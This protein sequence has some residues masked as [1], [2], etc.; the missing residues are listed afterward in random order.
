MTMGGRSAA[1]DLAKSA[2]PRAAVASEANE[3]LMM[4]C[5]YYLCR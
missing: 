2:P 3:V 4:G 1:T 5:V